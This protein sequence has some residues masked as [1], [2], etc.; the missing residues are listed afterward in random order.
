VNRAPA[1]ARTGVRAGPQRSLVAGK[2]AE[3]SANPKIKPRLKALTT[4][5]ARSCFMVL[6]IEDAWRGI[7]TTINGCGPR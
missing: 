7:M 3:L 1:N 5:R 6:S 4:T 2:E